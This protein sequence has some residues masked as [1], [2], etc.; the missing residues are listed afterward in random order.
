MLPALNIWRDHFEYHAQRSRSIPAG[1]PDLLGE[2]ERELIAASIATFQLGEQSSGQHLLRAAYRFA[3]RH[4]AAAIARTTELLIR[5]EQQHAALLGDFMRDHGIAC[6]RRDW[7]DWLF[8]RIRRA[9]QFELHLAVLLT[10]ELIG[11]VYYRAL[12]A[13]TGCQRL[14]LLCR[15]LVA[16]ELAHIGFESD[17]LLILRSSRAA[18]ARLI[19]EGAHRTLLAGAALVVW[20]THRPVLRQAGY[21]QSSFMRACRAQ[22]AFY[23]QPAQVAASASTV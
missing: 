2:Q 9:A 12:E 4:D 20:H 15:I 18:P 21:R 17:M 8:R 22:Y 1:V 14:R 11:I 10:A 13:A 5:E 7:T 3:H 6:K 23:M 19:V 16:D